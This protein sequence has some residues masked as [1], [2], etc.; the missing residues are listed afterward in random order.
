M[1]VHDINEVISQINYIGNRYSVV[2]FTSN[3]LKDSKFI[4]EVKKEI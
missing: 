3:T 4:N 1:I 2:I